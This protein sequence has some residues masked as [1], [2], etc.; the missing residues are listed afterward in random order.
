MASSKGSATITLCELYD[1]FKNLEAAFGLFADV[2]A[3]IKCQGLDCDTPIPVE[4]DVRDSLDWL[5][6]HQPTDSTNGGGGWP[7]C[8][9]SPCAV[10]PQIFQD[11]VKQ[12][13]IRTPEAGRAVAELLKQVTDHEIKYLTRPYSKRKP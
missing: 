5:L 2:L 10:A 7:Q 11:S 9:V 1:I 12:F 3:G 6:G 8:P 4:P 13:A